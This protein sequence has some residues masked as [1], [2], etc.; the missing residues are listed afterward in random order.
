MRAGTFC[1]AMLVAG[2][3]A[4]GCSSASATPYNYNGTYG[5]A[6]TAASAPMASS[7]EGAPFVSAGGTAAPTS[8]AAAPGDASAIENQIV[9]TGTIQVQVAS[10]DDAV[11]R[12]TDQIHAMGGWLAAS[13]RAMD[14]TS[15]MGSVT[16]RI[17][18]DQFENALAAMRKFGT[19]VLY[20]HT[21]STPVGGKIVDLKAQIANLQASET[22]IQSIM[23]KATTI[24]DVLTVQQ[25]LSDVQGQIEELSGQ[26]T[27]LTD[28]ASY[29]TLTVQFVV[30]YTAPTAS[31]S[32][33]VSPSPTPVPWSAADQAGQATGSLRE[34]GQA[35]ATALIWVVILFLPILVVSILVIVLLAFAGRRLDVYRRRW[36]PFTVAQPAPGYWSQPQPQP[37]AGQPVQNPPATTPVEPPKP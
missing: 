32:P 37:Y 12:A 14:S 5:A 6:A 22:A 17:P 36:L 35:G 31:P 27:G 33:T 10:I 30:P 20:E 2:V 1:F 26:M 15:Q 16:Y 29:S 23:S 34:V 3:V 21:E 18:V 28:Q 24:T 4:A 11:A 7:A 25:R 9:K 8:A 19:K 13:D